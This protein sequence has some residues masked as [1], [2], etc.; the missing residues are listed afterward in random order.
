MIVQSC[1]VY[2]RWLHQVATCASVAGLFLDVYLCEVCKS[3]VSRFSAGQVIFA[4]RRPHCV[5]VHFCSLC[6][7]TLACPM[8]HT[9]STVC[10]RHLM[11]G[12]T[13]HGDPCS[14]YVEIC[15]Q[16][17]GRQQ[18]TRAAAHSVLRRCLRALKGPG[19]VGARACRTSTLQL[20]RRRCK[21]L[22]VSWADSGSRSQAQAHR[23]L[24]C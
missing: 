12:G 11:D 10:L 7:C 17:G 22:V 6:A 5:L 1:C 23:C 24:L 14:L 8:V 18:S 2:S 9:C 15:G 3:L 16:P 20:M 21:S 13:P 19:V 4:S